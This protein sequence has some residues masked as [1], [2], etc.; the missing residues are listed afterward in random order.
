MQTG[1]GFIV[2]TTGSLIMNNPLDSV[3]VGGNAFFQQSV[4]A[5]GNLTDG[6]LRI[7]SSMSVG[8]EP[9]AFIA[10]GTHKTILASVATSNVNWTGLGVVPIQFQNL[11][12]NAN[13][14]SINYARVN[15]TMNVTGTGGMN[16]GR[17]DVRGQLTTASTAGMGIDSL[18]LG[19]AV[20]IAP[21]GG[22]VAAN[23]YILDNGGVQSIPTLP[24]PTAGGADS[25]ALVIRSNVTVPGGLVPLKGLRVD[26]SGR[27][28]LNGQTV[29]VNGDF[30]TADNGT[31]VMQNAADRLTITG[32]TTF[33]GGDESSLLT[34]GILTSSGRFTQ[35]ASNSNSSFSAVGNHLTRFTS[36]HPDGNIVFFATP[37]SA[38]FMNLET[39]VPIT[40]SSN[41]LIF[42]NFTN[43]AS[44]TSTA[45]RMAVQGNYTQNGAVTFTPRRFVFYGT[46][47]TGINVTAGSFRPDTIQFNDG[48]V[49]V[50]VNG[51]IV[52]NVAEV[53]GFG[54]A[55][56]GATAPSWT[57]LT[58][59]GTAQL[60]L[61]GRALNVA[62][63][64]IA[65]A[66][67]ILG[68]GAAS[69]LQAG[70]FQVTGL[71]VDNA[72]LILDEGGTT[73]AQQFNNVTFQNLTTPGAGSA[74]LTM[75]LVGSNST[76]RTMTFNSVNFPVIS[77]GFYASLDSS[78][79][80]LLQVVLAG[81]N[82]AGV[83]A[84]S[85]NPAN[86]STIGGAQIDW[87]P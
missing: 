10:T 49:T 22:R 78:N 32:A 65:S 72:R 77:D 60:N 73:Q 59:G 31:L 9:N 56:L 29:S 39:T 40:F 80:Q 79:D 37:Q 53:T 27:L 58:I 17:L 86:E 43:S 47:S 54:T 82:R 33:A 7:G 38:A 28:D 51:N 70:R 62:G 81:S 48:L 8:P 85:S 26:G 52:Y 34:D 41:I 24:V 46:L 69:S 76:P 18:F 63:P 23:V 66:G 71:T 16:V 84:A 11:E 67:S 61:N 25:S 5:T 36:N 68:N 35:D 20:P 12:A 19:G 4:D 57:S 74:L 30:W 64:L 87:Q 50:P 6:V 75:V 1:A 42:N 13:N 14:L 21:G 55:T 45:L 2:D 83:G 15:G 3:L 44:G